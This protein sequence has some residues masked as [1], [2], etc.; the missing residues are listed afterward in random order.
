[1]KN[2]QGEQAYPNGDVYR[3]A[4]EDDD[5]H[6]YGVITYKESQDV[7][8]GMVRHCI[9]YPITVMCMHSL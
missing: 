3:G 5:R 9:D 4:F 7:Y 8:R 2:G 1:M 6:G